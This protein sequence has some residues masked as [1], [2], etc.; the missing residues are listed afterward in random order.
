M[1]TKKQYGVERVLQCA[2]LNKNLLGK[3]SSILKKL[4]EE[5]DLNYL[6]CK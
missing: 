3:K 1:E 2:F 5:R 6:T 4:K